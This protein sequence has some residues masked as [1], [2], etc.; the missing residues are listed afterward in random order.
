MSL[1]LQLPG[2][3]RLKKKYDLVVIGGGPAA[4][5]A[6]LYSVRFKLDTL[7]IAE[8]MGGQ[9]TLAGKVENYLGFKSIMGSELLRR[10][11]DHVRSYGVEILLDKAISVKPAGEG[12]FRIETSR[13]G[14]VLASSVIIAIGSKRRKLG[15]PGEKE[16]D[17][18]GVSYCS[19]C[20]APLYRGAE[21]VVVVGGGDS[22]MEGARML[23]DYA[24]EV[25]LVHRRDTF[26]AQPILVDAV[27]KRP[28]VKFVL[29]SIVTEIIGDDKVR[30][31][32]IKNKVTGE[33][34]VIP[35][36]GVF[37]EIG[38]E[39][40]KEFVETLGVKTDNEGYIIVSGYMETSIEGIFAAGEC[41]S[42]WRG[43]RQIITSVAQGAVAAYGAYT[44]LVKSGAL[45]E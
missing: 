12:K 29:N 41:T 15:V 5:S 7:L 28:N 42:M 37:I 13:S 4:L 10:F 8:Q 26:R 27:E 9:L 6:A 34:R 45:R 21:R 32:R 23:S 22:A 17:G 14:S 33:E 35:V 18:K 16:Y 36:N 31:V 44:Y 20:D 11:E 19:I 1:R 2:K 39:P 38:S 40:H 43:F 25:L 30:A 24:R 3:R